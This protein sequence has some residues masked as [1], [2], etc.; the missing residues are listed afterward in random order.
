MNTLYLA[1]NPVGLGSVLNLTLGL[2]LSKV[3]LCCLGL[4]WALDGLHVSE[5][6]DVHQGKR[7]L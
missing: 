7:V 1:S 4:A 5:D 3:C 2:L 6:P